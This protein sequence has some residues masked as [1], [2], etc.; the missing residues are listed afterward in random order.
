MDQRVST[1]ASGFRRASLFAAIAVSAAILSAPAVS[2]AASADAPAGATATTPAAAKPAVKIAPDATTFTL[3]NGMQVVVV[4]DHRAPIVTHMVWYKIGAADDPPGKSGIAHFLEH[5]M[6][7]GTKA[8]PAG[9]F[10]SKVSEGGGQENAFTTAD[11]TAYYQTIGKQQL[12]TL[13]AFEADRMEGLVIDDAVVAP[14]RDVILEERRMRVDNNPASQLG[15]AI[16][17]ALYQNHHYGIPIIG[18]QQ[19]MQGLTAEDALAQYR[20]Y[21]TPNNAILV[22]AGDVTPEEVRRLAEA[23]FGRVKVRAEPGPRHRP[24]EPPPL[25]ARTVTL[26]DPRVTEPSW[27]RNYLV[28]SYASAKPG[29]AEALDV[30]ADILGRGPTSRLYSQ[31]VVKDGIA[32]SAGAYYSG[33][34]LDYGSFAVYAAPRGDVPLAKLE[35]AVD[36]VIADIRDHGV[37]PDEL[38]AAKRRTRAMAIYAQDSQSMLARIIGTAM[39]TGQPLDAV[40]EWPSRIGDVTAADITAAA[41]A[42]LDAR[43]SVTGSLIPA[44]A[45]G[46]S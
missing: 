4:P 45:Q 29:E 41:A 28:P 11:A 12:G 33:E 13:M 1:P 17:A 31:L 38:D 44:P 22:V 8:H 3:S 14:E 39:A 7:K 32:A 23:T 36:A 40:Q 10:S 9:E 19:E 5:L 21:Y 27:T 46:R 16:N 20:R 37:T 35:A 26:A 15:E 25:A 43:R 42:Y 34:A 2:R 6:F 30:L 18:W 24:M